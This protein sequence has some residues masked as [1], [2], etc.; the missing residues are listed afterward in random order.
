MLF[1][2]DTFHFQRDHLPSPSGNSLTYRLH[3]DRRKITPRH[4]RSTAL[5]Y[6]P[7]FTLFQKWSVYSP[8]PSERNINPQLT[9]PFHIP[10]ITIPSFRHIPQLIFPLRIYTIPTVRPRPPNLPTRQGRRLLLRSGSSSW[11]QRCPV[12]PFSHIHSS[13]RSFFKL[14]FFLHFSPFPHPSHHLPPVSKYVCRC[15]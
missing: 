2:R 11:C 13:F 8:C 10:L 1:P 12:R 6:P 7:V 4:Q 3:L 14:I 15:M 9:I 5:E